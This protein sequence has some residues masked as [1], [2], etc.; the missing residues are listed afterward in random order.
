MDRR[1]NR[2]YLMHKDHIVAE[3]SLDS[4]GNISRIRKNTAEREHMPLG[5]QM[6]DMKFHEWWKDRAT[7]KTRQGAVTALERLGYSSTSNMLV[8]NLALS[9]T[10]CY[11]IRPCD[12]DITWKDVSLFSNPFEDVFGTL[13]FNPDEPVD[14][15][16]QTSFIPATSQGEVQ[17]KWSIRPDG[18]RRLIKGNYGDNYQQS[19]NEV[20]AT[21]LHIIQGFSNAVH[22][23]FAE[24][25]LRDGRP[26]LGC[27]C[28]SFCSEHIEAVSA[29]EVLQ[30]GKVK[31]NESL[32]YPLRDAC[33]ALG[34]DG[35]DF[36]QFMSYEIMTDY[37]L[38]NI[39]RHMNNIAI[40]RDPDTLSVIGMAP[41]YDTGNSL[42]Y[43]E[44]LDELMGTPR[45]LKTHSFVQDEK[46]LL[47]YVTDRSLLDLT[48]LSGIDFSIYERDISERHSRIP[49]IKQRFEQKAKDLEAFQKGKN[50][51]KS[52]RYISESPSPSAH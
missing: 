6:N 45:P 43:N 10:D 47:K 28:D 22:Y 30:M 26:G 40:L 32:Y 9:L 46:K 20:F 24:I 27:V 13:T 19:I 16:N 52:D 7:P 38:S 12:S 11:W 1:I 34:I 42:F 37:L 44:S 15:R 17:K 25:K 48:K 3:M 50:I 49:F 5:G 29:W 33:V 51:W 23:S 14:L 31:Q 4:F 21:Q 8:D 39:D 2:V 41:I 35:H 18:T 36:D